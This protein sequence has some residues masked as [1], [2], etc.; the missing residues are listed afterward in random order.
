[1]LIRISLSFGMHNSRSLMS[2]PF[3][4]LKCLQ[5]FHCPG[6]RPNVLYLWEPISFYFIHHSHFIFIYFWSCSMSVKISY[7]SAIW[8]KARVKRLISFTT[9]FI[10]C[11]AM[12]KFH[13]H[14]ARFKTKSSHPGVITLF[15]HWWQNSINPFKSFIQLQHAFTRIFDIRIMLKLI[16][17]DI[18]QN[19]SFRGWHWIGNQRGGCRLS[20][21]LKMCSKVLLLNYTIKTKFNYYYTDL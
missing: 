16:L 9:P 3:W 7:L 12:C 14:R 4:L 18:G 13:K 5:H 15:L 19:T 21:K 6:S 8:A 2:D 11:L 10:W 1:M 20:S 17:W